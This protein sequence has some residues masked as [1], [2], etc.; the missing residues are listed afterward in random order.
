MDQTNE[1]GSLPVPEYENIYIYIY[2]IYTYIRNAKM[3]PGHFIMKK[4][5]S[6]FFQENNNTYQH[7]ASDYIS[8][9]TFVYNKYKLK[10]SGN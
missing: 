4:N 9:N 10:T 5:C 6:G 3:R 7:S 1:H 2:N 8:G